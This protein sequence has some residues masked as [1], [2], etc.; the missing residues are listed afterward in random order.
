MRWVLISSAATVPW[1]S[2]SAMTATSDRRMEFMFVEA[3]REELNTE[4]RGMAARRFLRS[5]LGRVHSGE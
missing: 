3:E 2:V 4:R 1:P 5:I